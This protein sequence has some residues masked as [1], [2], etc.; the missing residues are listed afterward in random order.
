MAESDP[1]SGTKRTKD[2]RDKSAQAGPASATET[3]PPSGP[4]DHDVHGLGAIRRLVDANFIGIVIWT[5]E[6]AIIDA[7]DA[8]LQMLQYSRDDL[9]SG[10]L[11]WTD[12]TPAD[13]R[14][15]DECAIADLRASGTFKLYEK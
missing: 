10:R 2:T 13:W 1:A 15:Q 11:R 14:D 3:G 8:F 12:L 4:L 6:G 5:L 7:N 9:Q